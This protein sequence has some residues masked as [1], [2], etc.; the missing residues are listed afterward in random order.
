M[1]SPQICLLLNICPVYHLLSFTCTF[2]YIHTHIHALLQSHPAPT[3][4]HL[5]QMWACAHTYTL[6]STYTTHTVL[7]WVLC[8]G[9]SKWPGQGAVRGAGPGEPVMKKKPSGHASRARVHSPPPHSPP[10]KQKVSPRIFW[11]R[12]ELLHGQGA[13]KVLLHK[14]VGYPFFFF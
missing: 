14:I 5:K 6:T 4:S 11:L 12:D 8:G 2:P 1:P 3:C 13:E 7:C 10:P 9:L